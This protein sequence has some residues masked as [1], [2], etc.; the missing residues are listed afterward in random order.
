MTTTRKKRKTPRIT[1]GTFIPTMQPEYLQGAHV[2]QKVLELHGGRTFAEIK[3]DGYRVQIHRFDDQL[4]A[5]TRNGNELLLE[6]YPDLV[7]SLSAL[8]PCI[9]DA[10]LVGY[11]KRGL[12]TFPETKARFRHTISPSGIEAYLASGIVEEH[13]LAVRAFDALWYE[14]SSIIGRPLEERR[15]YTER[16]DEPR[17]T[18][19]TLSIVDDVATLS[20][21]FASLC[22]SHYEGLV[23]KDPRSLYLSGIKGTS[24]VKL[25]RTET[26]DLAIAGY[27]LDERSRLKKLLCCT[28]DPRSRRYETLCEVNPRREGLDLELAPQ[29]LAATIESAPSVLALNPRMKELPE[30]YVALDRA[31]L[32][33]VKAMQVQ[34]TKNA[35]SCG[36]GMDGRAYSLRIGWLSRVRTDKRATDATT[37]E[38]VARLMEQTAECSNDEGKLKKR[39]DGLE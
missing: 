29:L 11:G 14:G 23:C 25:K 22:G 6:L 31:P 32:V 15:A 26:L 4:V 16:I 24:W 33:E 20:S 17:A 28:Y 13:P 10:E 5:Y 7:P 3:E 27:W 37:P 2:E 36:L 30:R 39:S 1:P 8:P 9:I 35:Y 21:L 18:P 38:Q 12:A 19:S 34:H